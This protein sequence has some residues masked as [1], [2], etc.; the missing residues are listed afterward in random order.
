VSHRNSRRV[1][2]ILPAAFVL[3]CTAGALQAQEPA[4]CQKILAEKSPA[5]VM[6]KF[7][8]SMKMGN[9]GE[10][11]SEMEVPATMISPEG[12]VVGSNTR[13]GRF[14]G[15]VS[16]YYGREF[17][18][19]PTDMKVLVGDDNQGV[20]AEFVARDTELDLAWIRIKKPGDKKYAFVDLTKA[21][22]AG[23][24]ETILCVDRME[25]YFDRTAIINTGQ[26]AGV[27]RKPR[28]L[29]VPMRG[30]VTDVGVP[31]FTLS[32]ELV[33]LSVMQ[34]PDDEDGESNRMS[35]ASRL[36]GMSSGA[37]S[38]ILPASEIAKATK[39]AL[40]TASTRP[41]GEE[42]ATTKPAAAKPAKKPA[43]PKAAD[44][45]DEK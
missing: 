3:A 20:E 17:S 37:G 4:V 8:L 16:R 5:V 31:I 10:Q 7:V 1:L 9:A 2:S 36:S 27:T 29:Y 18:A 41:A 26:V 38:M 23:V 28:E 12:L 45:D 44:K 33:G 42:E 19:K 22:K 39:R 11:Q 40:E 34:L 30:T 32:G 25:K 21:A 35:A 13:L 43:T 6:I 24:G 14:A 15:L